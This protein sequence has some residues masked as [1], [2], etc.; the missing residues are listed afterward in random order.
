MET[1]RTDLGL[2]CG[3]EYSRSDEPICA[4]CEK[5]II[6]E[7]PTWEMGAQWHERCAP[8]DLQSGIDALSDAYNAHLACLDPHP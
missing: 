7:T 5:P 8:P 6:N 2:G 1:K 4:G 3:G